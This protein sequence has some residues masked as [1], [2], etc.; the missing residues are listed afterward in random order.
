MSPFTPLA[1]QARWRTIYE[2]LQGTPIN[3]I[4]TYAIIAEKLDLH[5]VNDRHTIQVATRRAAKELLRID[6]QAITP[7]INLGYRV[8]EPYEHVGLAKGH[9]RRSNKS[10]VRAHETAIHVDVTPLDQNQ[11][12][13]L[14]AVVVALGAQ[15]DFCRRLDINQKR[16][17]DAVTSIG[18]SQ[19]VLATRTEEEVSEIRERLEALEQERLGREG[20]KN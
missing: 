1:E 6:Q 12:Q 16:L 8:V 15:M 5:P 18:K 14:G 7:V 13:A 19:Q 4:L 3:E 2:L 20:N 10:L 17:A 9:Q 11:R